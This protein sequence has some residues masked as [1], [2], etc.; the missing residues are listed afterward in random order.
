MSAVITSLYPGVTV[1]LAAALLGE[2]PSRRQD[3]GLALGALAVVL[4]SLG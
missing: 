4:V 1:G 2:R 3:L